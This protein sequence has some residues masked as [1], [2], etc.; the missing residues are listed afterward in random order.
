MTQPDSRLF[1]YD[2]QEEIGRADLTILYRAHRRSDGRLVMVRALAPEFLDDTYLV[3]RFL[4]AGQRTIRMDHPNIARVYEAD[5]RGD[6]VYVIRDWIE[7]ESLAARLAR[8]GSMSPKEVVPIIRQLA[9]ALDYAHSLRLMHGDLNDRCVFIGEDGHVTV[10][11]F[12]LAQALAGSDSMAKVQTTKVAHGAGTPEYL[13]SERAQGQGPSRAGDIYALGVLTYQMLAGRVP[14]SGEPNEV[15]QAQIH[16]VPPALH[17]LNASVSAALSE[18]VS[19]ALAKRPEMRFNTATEFAR[20]LGMAAEGVVPTR[21]PAA[22]G[23]TEQLKFWQHP[24]FWAVIIAPL[25]GLF[26]AVVLWNL[27]GWSKR[28]AARLAELIPPSP[29]SVL[30]TSPIPA[31]ASPTSTPVPPPLPTQTFTPAPPASPSP[32]PVATPVPVMVSEQSPFLN[33]IVARGISDDYQAV[34][35]G[36]EF[37]AGDAPV[38]LFFDYRDIQPGTRWGHVWF[39]GDQQLDRSINTWPDEWGSEGRAWVFYTPEGGYQPGPYEVR[40]LINDQTVASASFV[41]R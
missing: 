37:Q 2:V 30:E 24:I 11:D 41:M 27:A 35:P 1:A 10:A 6:V 36:R 29:P 21:T 22:A 26:L 33:L 4:E 19:R 38:Y 18:V 7:D 31:V 23:Q 5:Q 8:T 40:L 12:A 39:W 20:A 25:I 17:N 14:F 16:Q 13:S 15:L 9:A 34:L 3:R 28:G 32:T